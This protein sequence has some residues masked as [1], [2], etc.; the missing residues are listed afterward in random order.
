MQARAA[1][2]LAPAAVRCCAPPPPARRLVAVACPARWQPSRRAGGLLTR[3]RKLTGQHTEQLSHDS[4][5]TGG[6]GTVGGN[7][8]GGKGGGGGGN[9]GGGN[10]SGGGGGH[11]RRA[12]AL[13]ALKLTA[14]VAVAGAALLAAAP[15]VL[16]NPLGLRL[17][18]GLANLATP[19]DVRLHIDSVEAGWQLP[20]Q[21]HGLRLV[22]RSGISSS[23]IGGGAATGGS[24]SEDA[25]WAPF[26]PSSSED[27]EEE[28]VQFTAASSTDPAEAG[29][30]STAGSASDSST[31]VRFKHRRRSGTGT[32]PGDGSGGV[33][34]SRRRRVLVAVE[35]IRTT[36]TLLQLLLGSKADVIVSSPQVDCTLNAA[37]TPRLLAVL[38]Q[39]G[40]VPTP[41]PPPKQP[42]GTTAGAGAGAG[43]GAGTAAGGTS[44]QAPGSEGGGGGAGGGSSSGGGAAAT[45]Q[46]P[47]SAERPAA[48]AGGAAA[49]LEAGGA[50][51][52]GA[53]GA[54]GAARSAA[55][56]AEDSSDSEGEENPLPSLAE[57]AAAAAAVAAAA[58]GNK[59][60]DTSRGIR[61]LAASSSSSSNSTV[62]GDDGG[63]AAAPQPGGQA[64]AGNG[65]GG[66][67]HVALGVAHPSS[68]LSPTPADDSSDSDREE[69]EALAA[70]AARKAA[71]KESNRV[72]SISPLALLGYMMPARQP[73]RKQHNGDSG[74]AGSNGNGGCGNGGGG[75]AGDGSSSG[76]PTGGPRGVGGGKSW[77][78]ESLQHVSGTV[79]LSGE[80]RLEG[81]SIYLSEGALLVP[82]EL[83]E[84]LGA[85]VHFEVLRGLASIEEAAAEEQPAGEA[86]AAASAAAAGGGG[87]GG[88]KGGAGMPQT[89]VSLRLDS[90]TM[91]FRMQGWQTARG[92]TYLHRPVEASMLFTPALGRYIFAYLHPA[93]GG[94]VGLK[95]STRVQAKLMPHD[96]LWPT[97]QATLRAEPLSVD[98]GESPVLRQSAGVLAMAAGRLKLSGSLRAELS[99]LQATLS[100]DGRLVA[101]RL[102]IRI[103]ISPWKQG[104]H[105]VSWGT[106]SLRPPQ[107]LDATVCI[108][109]DALA[110]LGL[111]TLA[112]GAGLPLH[113]GG[114][115]SEPR[116]ER[117]QGPGAAVAS[118]SDARGAGERNAN[119]HS[120]AAATAVAVE[121]ACAVVL[122]PRAACLG[123]TCMHLFCKADLLPSGFM[124]SSGVNVT[125][126]MRDRLTVAAD[127]LAATLA[128]GART[129][130]ACI[131]AYPSYW[132]CSAMATVSVLE[133]QFYVNDSI[134]VTK[135]TLK[136]PD[137]VKAQIAHRTGTNAVALTLSGKKWEIQH[138][139]HTKDTHLKFKTAAVAGSSLTIKQHVPG[140][141]WAL[142]PNPVV[143]L[144]RPG[145]VGKHSK[146][147]ASWD[148]LNRV[149]KAEKTLYAGG[150]KQHKAY[151]KVSTATGPIAGLRSKLPGSGPLH[152]VAAVYSEK[153]GLHLAGKAKLQDGTKVKGSYS[154]QREVLSVT[155][156]HTAKAAT[157]DGP[158]T[159][160]TMAMDIPMKSM[161]D[162][163]IKFGV[164]WELPAT[165]TMVKTAPAHAP[166]KQLIAEA[167]AELKER[168]G[169]SL[170]AICKVIEQKH[171]AT[172]KDGVTTWKKQVSGQIKRLVAKGELVKVKS[173]YKLGDSLKKATTK[174]PAKKPAAPKAAKAAAPKKA[175][176]AKPKAAKKATPAKKAAAAKPKT[177]AKKA[178]PAKP[179]AKKAAAAP[180]V[181]KTTATK[182]AAPKKAAP[183]KKA[184]AKK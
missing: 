7:H 164:K 140:G 47:L 59:G 78:S 88:G 79:A 63:V 117:H 100:S 161:Q 2:R 80:L 156:K 160:L 30:G 142:V 52:G 22:A 174:K 105:L 86:A 57:A 27:D 113:I 17:A 129:Q 76:G 130:I 26:D 131:I 183:K 118:G 110:A 32:A 40:F 103:G 35:R 55:A 158:K 170:P 106:A 95:G 123:K 114:T 149:G 150:D 93:L 155:A 112:E 143:E 3:D 4:G 157:V 39:A 73:T 74:T 61:G 84:L 96:G 138:E 89:P 148:F 60:R 146:F 180:K 102:D 111:A 14:A 136:L 141:L 58:T 65:G 29:P 25:S 37:G 179:K 77:L 101:E 121:S 66:G 6:R 178:T 167:I 83:R 13:A 147:S 91:Q 122:H 48:A 108:P 168:S 152:S 139:P 10:S 145:L 18:L 45:A 98:L 119:W 72:S 162:P 28:A 171:G 169:S 120:D 1:L 51:R 126:A 38:Q 41:H 9:G 87:G 34:G 12:L 64:R 68:S 135:A 173:S 104:L 166:Y 71:R 134:C 99:P 70:A 46:A 50:Q 24:D 137:G 154:L 125:L 16:S 184:A 181:K 116:V 172:L 21:L 144:S 109:G 85:H 115:P 107:E 62:A 92:F 19:S 124:K 82:A 15:Y 8:G 175:A 176:A 43:T 31:A 56:A 49:G 127:T 11:P 67:R 165:T 44:Q 33:G 97:N 54:A 23:G 177:A 132:N 163:L 94:A 159:V 182:K 153:E 5:N 36:Q 53:G 133:S 20:L 75:T 42:P 69:E 81:A 151:A 90:P 128:I